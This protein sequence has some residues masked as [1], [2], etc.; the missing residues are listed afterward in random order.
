MVAAVV[1][2]VL[3][4]LAPVVEDVLVVANPPNEAVVVL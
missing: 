2:S 1:V 3:D 4:E